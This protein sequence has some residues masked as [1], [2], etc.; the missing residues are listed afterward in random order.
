[1][2]RALA[3]RHLRVIGIDDGPFTRRNRFAVVAAVAMTVPGTVDG[4]L[5]TRVRVDGKDATERLIDLLGRSPYLS[6]ARAILVDGISVAGF[7][8]LDLARMSRSLGRAVVSVTRREPD[9]ASIRAAI[10]T[11]FPGDA[12]RRYGLIDRRRPFAASIGGARLWLSVVGGT[13]AEARRL[14]LRTIVV[15]RWPEPLRLAHFLARA[16]AGTRMRPPA[17]LWTG[18][19]LPRRAGL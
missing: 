2:G 9:F 13:R 19:P 5:T 15:G 6:G 4:M 8:V 7:N 11:Y 14:V 10:R 12:S 17:T 1:L 3:K 16:T 18:D